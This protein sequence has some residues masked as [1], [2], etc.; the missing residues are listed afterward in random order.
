MNVTGVGA[1]PPALDFSGALRAAADTAMLAGESAGDVFVSDLETLSEGEM[2]ALLNLIERPEPPQQAVRLDD[3]LR[4]A[5]AAIAEGDDNRAMGHLTEFAALSPR[6]LSSLRGPVEA[7]VSRLNIT[8]KVDAEV[9]LAQA[10]KVIESGAKE[11]V[12]REIRT[13]NLV[14]IAGRLL[15][16]GGYA[17]FVWSAELSKLVSLSPQVKNPDDRRTAA[18]DLIFAAIGLVRDRLQLKSRTRRM[19]LRAPLL[20]LLLAWFGAG[21][22]GGV[23]S[24]LV[25][26]VWPDGWPASLI[27]GGFEI[28]AMGFLVL[29]AYAF[30][31]SVR[32]VRF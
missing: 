6:R 30:Y 8:A 28:W 3:L 7:L 9:Q 18:R 21:L 2:T 10:V 13:E 31:A 14:L 25:R 5:V 19:W 16:A 26:T 4:A 32:S 20:V 1:G 29:I 22:A 11:L 17:N 12:V 27:A 15:D 23:F 24:M